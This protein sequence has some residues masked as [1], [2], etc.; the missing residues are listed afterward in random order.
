MRDRVPFSGWRLPT[1]ELLFII[2]IA[3]GVVHSFIFLYLNGYLPVPYFYEP[4][5]TFMD[6]AAP[7]TFAHRGGAYD[8]FQTIYPPLSYVL[9]KFM[10]WVEPAPNVL[11]TS[12][13][14]RAG[15]IMSLPLRRE[16]CFHRVQPAKIRFGSH[17]QRFRHQPRCQRTIGIGCRGAFASFGLQQLQQHGALA[18]HY[19]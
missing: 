9:L 14:S 7:A 10:S 19:S 11:T 15:S 8:A 18:G 4:S 1:V 16:I 5:G 13:N 17:H 6:Y 2:P 12:M 3:I